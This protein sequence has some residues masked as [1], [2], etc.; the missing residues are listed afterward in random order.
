MRQSGLGVI[1]KRTW[2][3]FLKNISNTHLIDGNAREKIQN[4]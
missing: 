2:P 4:T 1:N 3:C